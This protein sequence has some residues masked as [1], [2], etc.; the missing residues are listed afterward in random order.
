MLVS[1]N[2]SGILV[3][4]K[5]SR[6]FFSESNL[7]KMIKIGLLL[8]IAGIFATGKNLV[9]SDT[10][11]RVDNL[12]FLGIDLEPTTLLIYSIV[13]FVFAQVIRY[14]IRVK[15]ESLSY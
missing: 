11:L 1:K 8:L 9:T 12:Y 7:N 13:M 5:R 6:V 15:E 14:G 4:T 3:N 10:I 2:L